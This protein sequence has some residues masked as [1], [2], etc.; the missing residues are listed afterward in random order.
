MRYS[1]VVALILCVVSAGTFFAI[2]DVP[3]FSAV[4]YFTE[5]FSDADNDL[6][7]RQLTFIPDS[8]TNSYHIYV[9]EVTWFPVDPAGGEVLDFAEND[10]EQVIQE[11]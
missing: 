8:S 6:A 7:F 5:V 9:E 4:E 2:Q 11:D 10:F 1:V 3:I